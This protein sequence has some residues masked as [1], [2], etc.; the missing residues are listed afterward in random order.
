MTNK[1][2]TNE[3]IFVADIRNIRD[4]GDAWN[5]GDAIFNAVY[6]NAHK[7]M[8]KDVLIA[9]LKNAAAMQREDGFVPL[10]V[11]STMPSDARVGII[12]QP[13]YAIANVA[14][15]CYETYQAEFD[16]ELEEFLKRLLNCFENNIIG[17]GFDAD[18]TVRRTMAMLSNKNVKNFI[19]KNPSLSAA[20]AKA[21]NHYVD[22][23]EEKLENG[24]K[25]V[26]GFD[27]D[28]VY[29]DYWQKII[30]FWKGYTEAVFVYGTLRKGERANYMLNDSVY[31]GKFYLKDCAMYNLGSYPGIKEDAG[32][33]VLGEVYF[34][35][36]E[37]LDRLDHYEGEGSL[38]NRRTVTAYNGHTEIEC[39]AYFYNH[40]VSADD[41][42]RQPWGGDNDY[43]WY[44]SYGSNLSEERFACYIMG[45]VC[46]QNGKFY[47]GCSDKTHW[48]ASDLRRFK[49]RLY[50]GNRSGSWGGKGVAFF[51][52]NG[53]ASVQ[54]R[55]YKISRKQLLEV[56]NQEGKSDSWYGRI[57]C[58]GIDE[59]GTEIYTLTSKTLRDE[60]APSDEY[61]DLIK[62]ALINECGYSAKA[63]NCYLASMDDDGLGENDID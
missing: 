61:L 14:I 42:M 17:H 2:Y 7:K 49:G 24:E 8:S 55:L 12:Y 38:Y 44:A 36:P 41:R 18:E 52:E 53:S 46:K 4:G 26:E 57:V 11:D 43:V 9:F 23:Y 62:T 1:T 37:I 30:S 3:N 47:S 20:L 54:M 15:Y 25:I 6:E 21:I 40:G 31:C 56:R 39:N 45:G 32:E 22:K 58:L 33:Y 51:D 16:A 60:N 59:D 29:N 50:F 5:I 35:T 34:I 28:T 48:K 63:V 13:S 27:R 10:F 19:E